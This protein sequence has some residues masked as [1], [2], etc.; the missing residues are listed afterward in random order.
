MIRDYE[1]RATSRVKDETHQVHTLAHSLY[2]AQLHTHTRQTLL[3]HCFLMFTEWLDQYIESYVSLG[4]PFLGAAEPVR[5]VF[6]GITL[7]LSSLFSFSMKTR[8]PGLPQ[9]LLLQ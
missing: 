3:L 4:A 7:G 2:S 9:P 5:G 1:R 8:A 6:A